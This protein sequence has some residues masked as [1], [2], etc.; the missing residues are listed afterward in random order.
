MTTIKPALARIL[1]GAFCCLLLGMPGPA[2]AQSP[3]PTPEAVQAALTD[4]LSLVGGGMIAPR[5]QPPQVSLDGRVYRIRIPLPGLTA[6]PNAAIDAVATLL[7]TGIWDVTSL[8]L[9]AAG[10]MPAD[11]DAPGT[12]S[13]SIARQAM[14]GKL[15]PALS[16]PSPFA[17]E[18]GGISVRTDNAGRHSDQ[19]IERYGFEGTLSGDADRKLALQSQGSAVNWRVGTRDAAGI[20]SNSRIKS[21]AGS[22]GIEGLDRTQAARLIAAGR[23]AAMQ[24]QVER[25]ASPT[26]SSAAPPGT[27]PRTPSAASAGL[28]PAL[29]ARLRAM[30]DASVGLLTRLDLEESLQDIQV[31]GSGANQGTIG[32]MRIALNTQARNDRLSARFD[33]TINDLTL[34]AVPTDLAGYLPNHIDI[35]PSVSG[36]PIDRLI[37]LLREATAADPPD[38]ATLQAEAIALLIEPGARAGIES[39]SFDLGPLRMEGSARL[40]RRTDGSAGLDVHL[41]ATGLDALVGAAQGNARVQPILPMAFLAKGLARPQGDALVWDIALADGT[42]TV[43]GM[44]FGQA[45][46]GRPPPANRAPPSRR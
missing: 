11:L 31:E 33:M 20:V 34:H 17:G 9:P 2:R 28:S 35:K 22:L 1:A 16:R 45:Y 10:S 29:R 37:R 43:N 5:A 38:Q 39:L 15:D 46:G 18:L 13:F 12:L 36:V 40:Q 6:P 41:V 26:A 24:M 44:P 23:S 21:V 42:V 19:T 27:V 32:R 7:P 4:A 30:V 3:A 25:P 14:H 8:T